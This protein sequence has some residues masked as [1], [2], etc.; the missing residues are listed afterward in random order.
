MVAGA[1]VNPAKLSAPT[2]KSLGFIELGKTLGRPR[3]LGEAETKVVVARLAQGEA[4]AALA[5][6]FGTSRQTIMRIRQTNIVV[7]K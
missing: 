4:V 6:A 1:F 2:T 7:N 3:S 5:R